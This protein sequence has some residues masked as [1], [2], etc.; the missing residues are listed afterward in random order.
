M[1]KGYPPCQHC[2]KRG[3]PSFKCWKRQNT[4]YIKCNQLG[5]EAVIRKTKPKKHE[6]YAQVADQDD[7]DQMFVAT[8]FSTRDSSDHWLIDNLHKPYDF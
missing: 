8:C 5:H 3:H 2:G 7:E 1:K 4:R 6:A